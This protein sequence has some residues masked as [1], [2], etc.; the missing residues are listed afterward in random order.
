[1]HT[2]QVTG[3]LPCRI[4]RVVPDLIS[5]APRPVAP[6]SAVRG[7]S[8]PPRFIPIV[9]ARRKVLPVLRSSGRVTASCARGSTRS[10]TLFSKSLKNRWGTPGERSCA[11]DRSQCE[12]ETAAWPGN[13]LSICGWRVESTNS[14]CASALRWVVKMHVQGAMVQSTFGKESEYDCYPEI[15]CLKNLQSRMYRRF[16]VPKNFV[17]VARERPFA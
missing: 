8:Y 17:C 9:D 10:I 1:V 6:R 14:L 11:F 5:G 15:K 16:P 3:I 12:T 13:H 4:A 2:P 7:S